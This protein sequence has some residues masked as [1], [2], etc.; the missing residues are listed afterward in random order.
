MLIGSDRQPGSL[1][2]NDAVY[3]YD[4]LSRSVFASFGPYGPP[5]PWQIGISADGRHLFGLLSCGSVGCSTAT[6]VDQD[7]TDPRAQPR[8][9]SLRD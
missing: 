3:V 8:R 5:I 9:L 7:A 4:V 2:T 1:P 6:L